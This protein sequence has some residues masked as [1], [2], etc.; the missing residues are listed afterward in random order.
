MTLRYWGFRQGEASAVVF[1][2][3]WLREKKRAAHFLLGLLE[4][5]TLK[6]NLVNTVHQTRIRPAAYYWNSSRKTSLS[7]L[8]SS[9]GTC[10]HSVKKSQRNCI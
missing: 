2:R 4:G 8:L 7:V 3:K 9:P 6:C 5:G 10:F 1:D